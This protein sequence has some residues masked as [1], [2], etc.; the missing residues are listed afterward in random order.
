[1]ASKSVTTRVS[2]DFLKE[3]Y[4]LQAMFLV[5]GQNTTI[6]EVTKIIAKRMDREKIVQDEII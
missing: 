2:E 4:K 6:V 1:M 3:V 5:K